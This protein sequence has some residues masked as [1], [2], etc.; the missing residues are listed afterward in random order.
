MGLAG[1]PVRH[2]LVI[3]GFGVGLGL[4]L[5]QRLWRSG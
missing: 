3:S 4:L 1:V 5:L 2:I